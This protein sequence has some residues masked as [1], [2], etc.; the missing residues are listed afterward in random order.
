M[1]RKLNIQATVSAEEREMQ[2]KKGVILHNIGAQPLIEYSPYP[3]PPFP[4]PQGHRC[5]YHYLLYLTMK[6]AKERLPKDGTYLELPI[7]RLRHELIFIRQN[8]LV[9]TFLIMWDIARHCHENGIPF[10]H[11]VGGRNRN[12]SLVNYCLYITDVHPIAMELGTPVKIERFYRTPK[13]SE[14][15]RPYILIQSDKS[16]W[17]DIVLYLSD[18][19]G[20][21]HVAILK[22]LRSFLEGNYDVYLCPLL[23]SD[24]PIEDFM[25]TNIV[26]TQNGQS[27]QI[28]TYQCYAECNILARANWHIASNISL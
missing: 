15:I 18:K 13:G 27:I 23:I 1:E 7:I 19:Y 5:A 8:N 11:V 22:P 21:K 2:H 10:D 20:I 26:T 14:L 28:A 17:L 16:G 9:D 3:L 24:V 25:P 4:I 12:C 6:G